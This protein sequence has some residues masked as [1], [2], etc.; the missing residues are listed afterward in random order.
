MIDSDV[1]VLVQRHKCRYQRKEC[2]YTVQHR[3]H[4]AGASMHQ[5]HPPRHHDDRRVAA[6]APISG[7][8]RQQQ[9]DLRK[10]QYFNFECK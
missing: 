9:C 3:E 8:V 1:Q 4:S 6:L 7:K 10:K 5:R 2:D